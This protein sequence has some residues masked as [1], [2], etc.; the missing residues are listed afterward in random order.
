MNE[1]LDIRVVR[2]RYMVR[3]AG[4]AEFLESD[5]RTILEGGFVGSR[6]LGSLCEGEVG[7]AVD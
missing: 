6:A 1:A 4:D 7:G 2:A 5:R 3:G